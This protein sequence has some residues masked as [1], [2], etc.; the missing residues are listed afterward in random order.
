MYRRRNRNV[1]TH[2]EV[3]EVL[4]RVGD[5]YV[6]ILRNLPGIKWLIADFT[7]HQIGFRDPLY[8]RAMEIAGSRQDLCMMQTG[9][10]PIDPL[11]ERNSGVYEVVFNVLEACE[12]STLG[13]CPGDFDMRRNFDEKERGI[14]WKSTGSLYDERRRLEPL[15]WDPCW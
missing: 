8:R 3:L 14:R 11:I 7:E 6:R 5:P 12:H 9:T 15:I 4:S 2:G 13:L 1:A 10:V